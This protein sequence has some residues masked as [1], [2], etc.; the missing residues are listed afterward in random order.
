MLF[1]S[2]QKQRYYL[3]LTVVNST[4][5]RITVIADL[6][7]CVVKF[8]ISAYMWKE[9]GI[10]WVIIDNSHFH[11][12]RCYP[13]YGALVWVMPKEQE[14]CGIIS[15]IKFFLRN[16]DKN[17]EWPYWPK[18]TFN[19]YVHMWKDQGISKL[20]NF[21][22]QLTFVSAGICMLLNGH[23]ICIFR[24]FGMNRDSFWDSA[25]MLV[26]TE[27]VFVLNVVLKCR[28]KMQTY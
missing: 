17:F 6:A 28:F 18:A 19:H 21:P 15:S 13:F 16:C 22:L 11:F 10:I 14:P 4:W 9:K 25:T 1:F 3:R 26:W 8:C 27:I 24:W 23:L 12:Q 2:G 7:V 5:I 20:K